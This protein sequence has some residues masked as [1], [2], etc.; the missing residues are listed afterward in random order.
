MNEFRLVGD[1]LRGDGSNRGLRW[2]TDLG[3][4]ITVG[5]AQDP[6]AIGGQY[7]SVTDVDGNKTSIVFDAT[8]NVVKNM[9]PKPQ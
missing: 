7:I 2:V 1:L 8:G 3:A 5:P 6:L 4:S 9:P